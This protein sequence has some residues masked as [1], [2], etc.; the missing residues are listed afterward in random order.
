MSGGSNVALKTAAG[1]DLQN[2]SQS[3]ASRWVLAV[4]LMTGTLLFSQP[5]AAQDVSPTP[6]QIA[7]DEMAMAQEGLGQ[8]RELGPPPEPIAVDDID[9]SNTPAEPQRIERIEFEADQLE[10]ENG[11]ETVRARG[12]VVLESEKRRIRADE[13]VWDRKA[14]KIVARGNITLR[15]DEGSVRATDVVWDRATKKVEA[16]GAIRLVDE[17]GNQLFTERVE[18]TDAFEVGAME[19]LLVSLRAGGRMAARTGERADDGTIILTDAAYTACAV[20]GDPTCA[21]DP[22]WRITA[23]R[24]R[25]NPKENRVR[26]DG[27]V[28]ELF[29]ARI[30]P[31]P[32]LSL[33]TDGKP[34]SGFLV[35]DIRITNVNGVELSSE[36]FLRLG[37]NKDLTLGARV[38]SEVAPLIT[39]EWR[40]LTEEGAY[41]VSG[42]AT[43]SSRIADFTG[44]PTSESD[45][46]GYL[47]ANGRYQF[48]PEWSV[49]GSLRVSSDRT[50]LRRYDISRDDRLRS[51][52]N[53]ERIDDNSYLSLAGWATQTLRINADQGQ[54]PIAL[55]AF[56]YRHIL[57]EDVVGGKIEL[58]ANT[59]ALL[60]T[61]GQDTQRAFAGAKWDISTLTPLGQIVTL[62]GLVRG[63]LYHT[64]DTLATLTEVYRGNEGWTA[65]G[66]A[67][68]AL[69]VE[70]PFVGEAFGG[71]QVLT[72]RAQLVASPPISNLAVP[73]EDAR[74]IDLEDS[75][76][77]ALNRFSGY[78][79]VEDGVRLTL[80]LDWDLRI[81]SW[82]ISTTVGQ[83]FRFDSNREIF[84]DGTGLS[85]RVSDFVGRTEVQYRDFISFTHRFRLDKDNLA[86][87]RNEIDATIGSPQTYLELGYLRLDRD[88]TTVEDLQDREEI[89]AAG[90][91]AFAKHWSIFGSGVFNLTG[92]EEDPTFSPDGFEPIRTRLG[93]AYADDSIE[94]GLTWRRDFITAGD[95]ERGNT[96]QLFF[97]VRNLGFR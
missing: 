67:T 45:P 5:V 89:R 31:L 41:Q 26:F 28:V 92:A 42:F 77:F 1:Q 78:D 13:V 76:L 74:A 14:D 90:R 56:D 43:V 35:P 84:P 23:D 72:P 96:F 69:D 34:E 49:T 70:W 61:D 52:F 87:R 12:N 88:I 95:A 7:L 59:L 33:R 81:P 15:T 60:R 62:T 80:G 91:V 55:P 66:V 71:T 47:F 57:E 75:N 40:H 20:S 17:N 32:G 37:E 93:V 82:R 86:V 10:Y 53:I 3:T 39:A 2:D 21:A 24:V 22:S 54:I 65:R 83:S 16:S 48:T 8:P 4:A 11:T 79:R 97:A 85:E 94:F 9:G 51:T 50:F 6:E 36:Y 30:L 44:V 46:R 29:G 63:D 18:L 27:A 73:N 64:R 38:Y 68:A 25:F 58:Q 19:D